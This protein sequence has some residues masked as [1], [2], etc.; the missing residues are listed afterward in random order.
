VSLLSRDKCKKIWVRPFVPSF[1][2]TRVDSPLGLRRILRFM[3]RVW[4][5]H[6]CRWLVIVARGD[7][8]PNQLVAAKSTELWCG[9]ASAAMREVVREQF[10]ITSHA[11]VRFL[12][13]IPSVTGGFNGG[14]GTL[15]SKWEGP[16]RLVAGRRH[17][18]TRE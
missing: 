7:I 17:V 18:R 8:H 14:T 6:G 16:K 5:C 12:V 2:S 9:L 11:I 1:S 13:M 4:F 10:A 3:R 15:R